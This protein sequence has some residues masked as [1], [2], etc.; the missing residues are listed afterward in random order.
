MSKLTPGS[1]KPYGR[2]YQPNWALKFK[3]IEYDQLKSIEY[4]P[5]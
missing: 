1:P 3:W 4:E 2:S 5:N